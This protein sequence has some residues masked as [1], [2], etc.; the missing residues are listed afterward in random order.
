[1]ATPNPSPMPGPIRRPTPVPTPAREAPRAVRVSLNEPASFPVY[2]NRSAELARGGSSL[3]TLSDEDLVALAREGRAAAFD[4]LAVRVEDG[5]YRFVRRTIGDREDARDLCQEALLRAW[6]NLARLRDARKFSAWVHHIALNLCRD[7]FRSLQMRA[8][9]RP[10]EEDAPEVKRLALERDPVGPGRGA[11]EWAGRVQEVEQAL[12]R[13]PA[14]QRIAILLRECHGFASDE[15][16]EIT[17]VP[18]GTVRTRI[19][20]GLRALRRMLNA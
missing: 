15:I 8:E 16:A 18:A 4:Q 5:V 11:A 3:D 7:R 17:G 10:W 12:A 13:L 14:E 1:V 9:H 6:V 2:L 20:H 19:F